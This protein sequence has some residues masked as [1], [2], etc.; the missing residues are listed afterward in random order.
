MYKGGD[1]KLAGYDDFCVKISGTM[2]KNTV[3]LAKVACFEKYRNF[4][5]A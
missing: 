2:Y 5:T 3:L 1:E 4:T